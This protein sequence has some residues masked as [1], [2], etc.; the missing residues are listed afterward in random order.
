ML[1]C[2]IFPSYG[3]M[4]S[5][6]SQ[7]ISN[8]IDPRSTYFQ[9]IYL[10]DGQKGGQQTIF[11]MNVDDILLSSR[12]M[13]DVGYENNS[14]LNI[15]SISLGGFEASV[16]ELETAVGVVNVTGEESTW[17]LSGDLSLGVSG[18]GVLD[19]RE[20]GRASFSKIDSG[21]NPGSSSQITIDGNG[22]LLE[23]G[24][25]GIWLGH[26]GY[27][28]TSVTNGGTLSCAGEISLGESGTAELVVDSGATLTSNYLFL[29]SAAGSSATFLLD[30]EGTHVL[31]E[32][33][34]RPAY[35]GSAKIE[36]T[37][38][39][40]LDY[41]TNGSGSGM[42]MAENSQGSA[43]LRIAGKGS[44]LR[45]FGGWLDGGA[46]H[47][48]DLIVEDGG[49]LEFRPP[50]PGLTGSGDIHLGCWYSDTNF[51]VRGKG[52]VVCNNSEYYGN[53]GYFGS[54]LVKGGTFSVL[55]GAQVYTGYLTNADAYGRTGRIN[56][57]GKD[58]YV[59]A[60]GYDV[61][62]YGV[63][64]TTV[65]DGACLQVY[66]FIDWSSTSSG[67]GY[68]TV[69]DKGSQLISSG[70]WNLWFKD[71]HEEV[72]FMKGARYLVQDAISLIGE[73]D[74]GS[75]L[76]FE[77]PGTY[78]LKTSIDGGIELGRLGFCYI[79]VQDKALF[80]TNFGLCTINKL[81]PFEYFHTEYGVMRLAGGFL[82]CKG[83]AT[84][85]PEALLEKVH[86]Q[87]RDGAGWR[88]AQSSDLSYYYYSSYGAGD[89][90]GLYSIYG[91]EIDLTGYTVF[92]EKNA[93]TYWGDIQTSN[94]NWMN[95]RWYGTYYVDPGSYGNWIWHTAHGW[96]YVCDLGN[97][98][99]CCWDSSTG[100][101]LY[102]DARFYPAVYSYSSGSWYYYMDGVAPSRV[103]YSYA[104]KRYVS[105]SEL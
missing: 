8:F 60:F 71:G 21:V 3:E 65:S 34:F 87:L 78:F 62:A 66:C 12:S 30:G 14:Q 4:A 55:D 27:N 20:G 63:G 41:G 61:H 91:S 76:S 68:L 84:V 19:I 83:T 73:A 85:T 46:G 69:T 42:T 36:I 96:Q 54:I 1:S 93:Q 64:Y 5:V 80:M 29:G 37:G 95:S 45:S 94:G 48:D 56:I 75:F 9:T 51:I 86:V 33:E 77:N 70:T 92:K 59:L 105:E 2:C 58:T 24:S 35:A 39:A 98:A 81:N 40:V 88:D 79:I 28:K 38:G 90:Y 25:A 31:V 11:D 22:S 47:W 52:S 26:Q 89:P 43:S 102:S 103:F 23:G 50:S 10:L 32:K 99:M 67:R 44:T 53:D 49:M 6:S 101:W 74:N 97:R 104:K 16:G 18:T 82:A 100:K 57:S 72:R 7:N 17:E 15:S 13:L